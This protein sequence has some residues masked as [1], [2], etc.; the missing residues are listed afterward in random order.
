MLHFLVLATKRGCGPLPEAV[1]R[2]ARDQGASPRPAAHRHVHW[3]SAG[4]SVQ[5]AGWHD[6]E[7]P[8][9]WRVTPTGLVAHAGE[10][11]DLSG[12]P[13]DGRASLLDRLSQEGA[14]ALPPSLEGIYALLGLTSDGAVDIV[15]D[16][17][18]LHAIYTGET[19][20]MSVYANDAHLVARCLAAATEV[21]PAPNTDALAMVVAFGCICGEET[22]YRGVETVPFGHGIRIDPGT[23]RTH[24]PKRHHDPWSV[25]RVGTLTDDMVEA[26][27]DRMAG[28]MRAAIGRHP[29]RP[30]AELT[31][32]K[33]SRLVLAMAQHGGLLDEITFFTRGGDTADF[34]GAW[35][36]AQHMDLTF[37]R[38]R[39][40]LPP[41]GWAGPY[42]DH[43][44]R[45]VGQVGAW[46]SSESRDHAGATFSGLLGETLRA[47]S[48]RLTGIKRP[49][50]VVGH[51]ERIV[52]QRAGPLRDDALDATV[53]KLVSLFV[54]PLD[55]GCDASDLADIFYVRHHQRRLFGSQ[56][57]RHIR[58]FYPLYATGSAA[59]AFALGPQAR[60][61][62]TLR[63][64]LMHRTAPDLDDLGFAKVDPR[65]RPPIIAETRPALRPVDLT[66]SGVPP[67]RVSGKDT[68]RA[69]A[70]R[71][72]TSAC[73]DSPAFELIDRAKL[74]HLVDDYESLSRLD[75]IKAH[76]A[77]TPIIWLDQ[78][79]R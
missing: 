32:G 2:L 77:I 52:R 35:G 65:K 70:L 74:A 59:A 31:A 51:F 36:V 29:E 6:G 39:W 10:A 49:K 76:K 72:L 9:P 63:R 57:D 45:V 24:T 48:R 7:P 53:A 1:V 37:R 38:T 43:V 55:E 78:Q 17:F 15:A 56:M 40:Y 41:D 73:S 8:A 61:D 12:A 22:P 16:P 14:S 75:Q 27:V 42:R 58:Y 34:L 79:G 66:R 54:E 69:E 50:K 3:T 21:D 11:L 26:I 60:L 46:E 71:Q 5:F 68:T 13:G 30:L 47:S 19:P 33:D 18:G 64:A 62:E 23:G 4:G 25:E 44:A 67:L 28:L 20:T